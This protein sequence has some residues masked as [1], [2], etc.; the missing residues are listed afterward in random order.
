MSDGWRPT[1][2]RRFVA[3]YP[4]STNVVRVDTDAGEGFLKALGNPEGPH[5]LAC[6]L[7]GTML[8]EWLGLPTLH[9]AVIPVTED[10]EIPFANGAL[11]APGPA[12][13]TRAEDGLSWGGDAAAIGSSRRPADAARLVV[14]DTWIR[15]C[16][17]YRP[18]PQLRVNRDNVFL[19]NRAGGPAGLVLVAMDHSHSF[20]CGAPLS[21][22][23]GNLDSVRDRT[24]FGLFP[25]FE[26]FVERD[27]IA[28]AAV[29]LA[30][31]RP[32]I[33]DEMIAHVPREWEVEP[34]VRESWGT[35]IVD[36]ARF[37]ADNIGELI[38]PGNG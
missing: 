31:M 28:A 26:Q 8:A 7:V 6:E 33:A 9:H 37:L 19:A 13:I 25:E 27:A 23:I 30:E 36:R 5:V 3:S 38:W 16:D 21:P 15:N 35:F 29:Q 14:L 22:R 34:A 20:T 11:A 17:R 4:T 12:F 10:D 1:T 24:V 2:I 18:L 32:G